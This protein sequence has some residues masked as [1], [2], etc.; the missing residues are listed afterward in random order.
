M[1]N[2]SIFL[3]VL[4]GLFIIG[5]LPYPATSQT[6]E[7][8]WPE[9]KKMA[10]SLTF[11]DARTSNPI[12]G[13]PLLDEY[14]VD[15]TFYVLPERVKTN[16]AGWRA[17]VKE[18]HEMAN[19]SY[20][21]PCSGNFGWARPL[22]DYT[23][24][25][26]RDELTEANHAIEELLGVKPVSYA[27]PCGQT[28]IGRGM[29]SQSFI[30]LISEMFVTGRLWLSEAPVDPWY[31]DMAALTGMKMDNAEFDEILPLIE[32]ATKK[33]QWL[34]LAGH[35]TGDS[36]NQTTYLSML[37]KL[38][39][40][41]KDPANGIW[42][43]PVGTIAEY[44]LEKRQEFLDSINIPRI[45]YAGG[46]GELVL[47]AIHA[48]AVGPEIQYMPEWEAFGWFTGKDKVE[49][50]VDAD[51][52][53]LYRVQMEWSVSD[54]E[55][56]K[57]FIL[58]TED[59]QLRGKVKRSGSWETF[60]KEYIGQ[61]YLEKGY[62][63]ITFRPSEEFETGALLDLRQIRLTPLS[64]TVNNRPPL[65]RTSLKNRGMCANKS[66]DGL[67]E[68][69]TVF[70]PVPKNQGITNDGVYY[71]V[72]PDHHTI[73]KRKMSNFDLI[74]SATYPDKI[75]GLFF[76]YDA[77]EI[78]TCSGQ[79]ETGGDAFVSRI[80]KNTLQ[81]TETIDISKHTR[82]GVNA[83]VRLGN[84][85]YVGETAV[86]DDAEPKSWFSFDQ[87]FDFIETVYSHQSQKGSYDWQDATVYNGKII[88]TDHNGFV[89]AF[90]VLPNGQLSALGKYDS[91]GRYYE[92]ITIKEN[93]FYIW[94]SKVGIIS[95]TL[96]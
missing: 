94:K 41:A 86:G 54:K 83:I 47:D 53:G 77:D 89:F 24:D 36:G 90:C 6:P 69:K 91:S 64:G 9:G 96:K 68:I 33:G 44:V 71:Y 81:I 76:D 13:I 62:Q 38:C 84:K 27:Y 7:F 78:L 12:H 66:F 63:K 1:T 31:C 5:F 42:I 30:S 35:E 29:T 52:S 74:K 73:E 82:H 32:S 75:G 92:G 19:H 46:Y 26:M 14:D 85:Y 51:V 11:D 43:A 55:A 20:H 40:Y 93:R 3:R 49:W 65:S 95:A 18:G 61:I 16:L 2:S 56:G 8:P 50:E 72:S 15:A 57:E 22:E 48:K 45:T 17:A 88:A 4:L 87:H 37:R 59:E 39:E 67:T 70:E 28:T 80:N 10:I 58:E 79:Y 25:K 60:K 34:I 23:T 21:H